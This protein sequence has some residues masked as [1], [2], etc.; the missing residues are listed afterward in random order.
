MFGF[1]KSHSYPI[2][3]DVNG[4][5]IRLVQLADNGRTLSL[6]AGRCRNRPEDI[7][8][9]SGSWQRWAIQSIRLFTSNGDFS[10]KDVS[11]AIPARDLFIDHVRVPKANDD[12]LD[13]VVFGKIKSRLPFDAVREKMMMKCIR[14]D[15]ENVLV[16]AADRKIIERH[17]AIYEGANLNIKSM[18]VWPLALINCYTRFFGRRKSDIEGVVMLVSTENDCTNV[19]ICRYNNLLF[20]RSIPIGSKDFDEDG[21]A[22]RLAMELTNCRR[23]YNSMHRNSQLERVIFLTGRDVDKEICAAIAKQLEMPAQ[24]GD[25]LAAVEIA[26]TDRLG[27]DA[28][29]NSMVAPKLQHNWTTAFGLSLS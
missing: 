5:S 3:I 16:M 25:C 10:G 26:D 24:R 13:E 9:G 27:I 20:A 18:G 14:T 15:D 8:P 6:V 28:T 11:A 19:V 1:T 17:L 4:D 29:D 22:G 23:Q 21:V 7:E 12:K 2:G